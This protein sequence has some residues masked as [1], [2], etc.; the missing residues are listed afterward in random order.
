MECMHYIKRTI[1]RSLDTTVKAGKSVLLLGPRQTGKSTL[2]SHIK[3]DLLLNFIRPDVR[4]RYEQHPELLTKETEY[5][6]TVSKRKPLVVL[7]EVQRVP[8]LMDVVQDL[9]DRRVAQFILLGS[10]ARKLRRNASVNLLPGRLLSFRLDPL[11]QKEWN[12][13]PIEDLLLYGSLPGVVGEKTTA[14]KGQL[15]RS[16]VIS[17]LEEEVR[18]EAL[19]RKIADFGRFLE[20]AAAES[21]QLTNFRALSQEIGIAH[22]TIQSYYRILEDCLIVERIEP[23][24]RS[25]TRRKLT[26][27]P[28]YLFF[29]LGVRRI[30]AKESM[31]LK[32]DAWGQLLEQYVGLELIRIARQQSE[33]F[34]VHFWRDPDGPE[35]DW[36]IRKEKELIPIEV[37]WTDHPRIEDARHLQ[38]FMREYPETKKAFVVCRTPRAYAL[39]KNIT[40]IPIEQIHHIVTPPPRTQSR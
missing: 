11:S 6:A 40:A 1:T 5:L 16:Y 33:R 17:Y 12:D 36:V 9:I 26:K 37:K 32:P 2:I 25:K 29:D 22:T 4:Q 34:D 31:E 18:A 35:V 13:A 23:L 14:E 8:I 38:T 20:L 15:L 30:A 24:T 27:S 21:G 7:D 10:S 39:A 28:K 19:V 3:H